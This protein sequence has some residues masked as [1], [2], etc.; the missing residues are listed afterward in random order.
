MK[1]INSTNKLR[2]ML[3]LK[4]GIIKFNLKFITLTKSVT[5]LNSYKNYKKNIKWLYFE[6]KDILRNYNGN[7]E[8]GFKK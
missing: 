1:W 5:S 4:W 7:D 6:E 8:E 2:I 3:K